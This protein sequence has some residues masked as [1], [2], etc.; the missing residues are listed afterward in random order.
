MGNVS[1]AM[2]K[3]LGDIFGF[4]P[5]PTKIVSERGRILG[6]GFSC[7]CDGDTNGCPNKQVCMNGYLAMSGCFKVGN[8]DPESRAL[9][10]AW[11][12]VSCDCKGIPKLQGSALAIVKAGSEI[13]AAA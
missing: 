11:H 6:E 10:K 3:E 12:A 9:L 2:I 13:Y 4:D 1:A 5:D 8:I 7:R